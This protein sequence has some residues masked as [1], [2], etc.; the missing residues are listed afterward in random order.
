MTWWRNKD[1]RTR[2]EIA[3]A[4]GERVA[5]WEREQAR[6]Q[7]AERSPTTLPDDADWDQPSPTN[8]CASQA[9]LV[10]SNQLTGLLLAGSVMAEWFLEE[11][12]GEER[13]PRDPRNTPGWCILCGHHGTDMRQAEAHGFGCAVGLWL[14]V[15]EKTKTVILDD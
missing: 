15:A 3:E 1:R 7:A 5:K 13:G 12:T 8:P 14:K 6:E 9:V 10:S 11:R 4:V 2:R